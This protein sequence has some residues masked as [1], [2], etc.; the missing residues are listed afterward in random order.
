MNIA[1]WSLY[2]RIVKISLNIQK[3]KVKYQQLLSSLVFGGIAT[4][5]KK[6]KD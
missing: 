2:I 6:L 3:I 5:F 1:A 4:I